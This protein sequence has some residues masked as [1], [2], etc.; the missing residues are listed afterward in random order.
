[1]LIRGDIMKKV[2]VI[3][4]MTLMLSGCY[5]VKPSDRVVNKD[6]DKDSIVFTE[7]ELDAIED[8]IEYDYSGIEEV[9][10]EVADKI[11]HMEIEYRDSV[12]KYKALGDCRGY[13]DYF[14]NEKLDGFEVIMSLDGYRWFFKVKY[15]NDEI[16]ILL[17]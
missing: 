15:I 12:T 5:Y 3:L 8:Y 2:L 1:M 11:I 6:K 9:D 13:I 14:N 7:R 4:C 17:E 16:I 10:I